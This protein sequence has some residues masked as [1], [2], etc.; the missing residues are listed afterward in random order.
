[1]CSGSVTLQDIYN[2]YT[3]GPIEVIPDNQDDSIRFIISNDNLNRLFNATLLLVNSA[4]PTKHIITI[5]E[6]IVI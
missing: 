6:C 3:I 4:G 5:S 2:N 1:M